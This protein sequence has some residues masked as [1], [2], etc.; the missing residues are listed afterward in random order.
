MNRS[1]VASHLPLHARCQK[2]SCFARGASPLVHVERNTTRRCCHSFSLA[3]FQVWKSELSRF[4]WCVSEAEER[5]PAGLCVPG[6]I[7]P[8]ESVS[9]GGGDRVE[10]SARVP[11]GKN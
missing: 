8:R 1:Q 4:L 9:A 6:V 2:P 10:G 11:G 7:G 5:Q 3:V